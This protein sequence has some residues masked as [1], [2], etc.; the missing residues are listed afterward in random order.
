LAQTFTDF[1]LVISNNDST[2]GTEAICK[3]YVEKDSR[4]KYVKQQVNIGAINNFNFLLEHARGIY[5]VWLC[6]D[7]Y[8]DAF[9][10]EVIT[11][12]LDEHSD[13]ALCFSDSIDVK[14][15][16]ILKTKI[17]DDV[18]ENVDWT[19]ARPLFFT[20]KHRLVLAFY[21]IYRLNIMQTKGIYLQPGFNGI[22]YGVE[23]SIL[24][25]VAL[26][27]RIVALPRLLKFE[28]KHADSLGV[29]EPISLRPLQVFINVLYTAINY[30][31][32]VVFFSKLTV[33]QKLAI[34]G[35]ILSFNIPII[36]YYAWEWIPNLLHR[37]WGKF[38]AYRLKER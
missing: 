18:R 32:R 9:F 27:G 26:Q 6:H 35:K 31:A 5:F 11:R 16:V 38:P 13:V 29:A 4:I 21:G 10:L 7:D 25:R 24:P 15:G 1:E 28:R 36:F 12:Y 33:R 30:Q 8:F 37:W 2:D 23:H 17:N 20:W 19:I 3:E 34:Y 14:D 22:I